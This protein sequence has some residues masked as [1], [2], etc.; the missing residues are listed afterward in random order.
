MPSAI[1]SIIF[2]LKMTGQNENTIRNILAGQ[3]I[4]YKKAVK[5]DNQFK[6]DII[7]LPE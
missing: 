4:S 2:G 5:A 3:V 1:S 7:D 6:I